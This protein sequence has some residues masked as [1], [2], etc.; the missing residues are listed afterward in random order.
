MSRVRRLIGRDQNFAI[1]VGLT[2]LIYAILVPTLGPR[3]LSEANLQSMATQVAEFGLLALAMG[4]AMLTAGIDLSIVSAAVLAAVV[5]SKFLSGDFITITESNQSV[6]MVIGI[7][8]MLIT[9]M[10]TGLVNGTLVAKFSVPPILATLGTYI[11]F[12]GISTVITDARAVSVAVDD[13]SDIAVITVANVPLIFVLMIVAYIAVAFFLRNVR[14]GRR[15]YLYGENS[16]ALRF[17]G[18]R[19][20]RV[21]MLTYI[22]IGLLA[23]L[24]GLIISSR[25]N[26]VKVGYGDTYLLQAILVVVL[27]GFNPYGGRGRVASLFVGLLMLQSLQ[28][29]FTIMQFNPFMRKFIWGAMLL[30]VM[31]VNHVVNRRAARATAATGPDAPPPT[32][33]ASAK[34]AVEAKA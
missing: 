25:A 4:L 8:A 34:V 29:A 33:P 23:G 16:V 26:G 20:E 21:V 30:V 6:V 1:L 9:G 18:A 2:I 11:V 14:T 10:L 24:A 12:N 28:S 7:V 13:Y 32:P 15:I 19:N 5:G 3:F 27:A 22:L 17:T 31:V